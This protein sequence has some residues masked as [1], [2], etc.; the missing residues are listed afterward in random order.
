M[1]F[2]WSDLQTYPIKKERNFVELIIL[3]S[4]EK[5]WR[6]LLYVDLNLRQHIKSTYRL[7]AIW[8]NWKHFLVSYAKKEK[9]KK[10]RTLWISRY[11]ICFKQQINKQ[12]TDKNTTFFIQKN[13]K[14][15]SGGFDSSE[16]FHTV[17]DISLLSHMNLI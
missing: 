11:E 5:S 17:F 10:K 16:E 8:T 4:W 13:N 2:Y 6:K 3:D 15:V 12:L 14:I 1:L 9:E 7:Q